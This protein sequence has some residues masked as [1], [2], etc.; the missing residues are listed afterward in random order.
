MKPADVYY[1]SGTGNT[2]LACREIAVTL[3]ERGVEAK[4]H[5][6]ERSDPAAVDSGRT[7]G[8]T[9]PAAAAVTYPIVLDFLHRLP[10][11]GGAGAFAFATLGGGSLDILGHVRG[12]LEAKG[13]T[14]L[15]AREIRMPFNTLIRRYD[16]ESTR[17]QLERGL[18]S[19][20]SFAVDLAEGRGCWGRIPLVPDLAA[21]VLASKRAWRFYGGLTPLHRDA[22][23]CTGCGLCVSICPVKAMRLD[24]GPEN[25]PG[26]QLC[27]RCVSYCP[28]EALY[29]AR[30]LFA[31]YRAVEPSDFL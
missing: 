4:L 9:F 22:G 20:C 31:R 23:K 19:A 26:C 6:I 5:P 13:Y 12:I 24:T 1:F 11:G 27:L 21:R 15:G 10:P 30:N 3:G 17:R 29:Y 16:P 7:I 8:V 25:L 2:L 14:P 28:S 18:E